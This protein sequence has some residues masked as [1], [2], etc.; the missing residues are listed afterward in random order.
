MHA[1]M[2]EYVAFS[3][4]Q[5]GDKTVVNSLSDFLKH[6]DTVFDFENVPLKAMQDIVDGVA[7]LHGKYIVHRDLKPGNILVS[8]QHYN[9]LP[10]NVFRQQWEA[11]TL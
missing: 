2:Q 11:G 1:L 10:E 7:F 8:N 5:L 6:A 9:D 4:E 3:F